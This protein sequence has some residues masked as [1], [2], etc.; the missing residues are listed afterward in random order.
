MKMVYFVIVIVLLSIWDIKNMKTKKQNKDLILYVVL[1]LMVGF[2]G[3]Y[4]FSDPD[5][6]FSKVIL[7]WI[8]QGE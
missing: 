5:R 1:M 2:L 8:G 4:Y 6:S 3:I 7:S